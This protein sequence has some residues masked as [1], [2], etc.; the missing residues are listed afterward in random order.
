MFRGEYERADRIVLIIPSDRR[1]LYE[2]L[3]NGRD[4]DI[5]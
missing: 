5:S 4:E 1:Y 2:K 3:I